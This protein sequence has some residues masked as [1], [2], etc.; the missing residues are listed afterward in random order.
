MDRISPPNSKGLLPSDVPDYVELLRD[1]DTE[2]DRIS[3]LSTLARKLKNKPE[4]HSFADHKGI[5]ILAGWFDNATIDMARALL[6]AIVKTHFSKADIL[7]S[8]LLGKIKEIYKI[9]KFNDDGIPTISRVILSSYLKEY[10]DPSTVVRPSPRGSKP[11]EVQ[12][13]E[14]EELSFYSTQAPSSIARNRPRRRAYNLRP[15]RTPTVWGE[16]PEAVLKRGESSTEKETQRA[17]E[18]TTLVEIF[19][20]E[21]LSALPPDPNEPQDSVSEYGRDEFNVSVFEVPYEPGRRGSKREVA[22]VQ[23]E[24]NFQEAHSSQYSPQ[25]SKRPRIM[26][27]SEDFQSSGQQRFHSEWE[28]R[29]TDNRYSSVEVQPR[30]GFVDL[31]N[32]TA[33]SQRRNNSAMS[34][35]NRNRDTDRK[36][37]RVVNRRAD[38]REWERQ[39]GS[40]GRR[41]IG[42]EERDGGEEDHEDDKGMA[43]AHDLHE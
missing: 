35:R 4:L 1:V 33:V 27:D 7:E 18:E 13:G 43:D 6:R 8:K 32:Q 23:H 36:R 24:G 25:Y 16:L 40:A 19:S 22:R 3:V 28:D 9:S 2:K 38:R 21:N 14:N 17:R 31:R 42:E 30:G 37:G 41:E 15:W 5:D 39:G 34:S 12:F 29:E 26:R 11:K 20:A 10:E